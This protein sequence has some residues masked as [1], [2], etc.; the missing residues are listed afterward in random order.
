MMS[1]DDLDRPKAP[2]GGPAASPIS[3]PE[4]R[5]PE[6]R[7]LIVDDQPL[8]VRLLRRIVET[9]G[10]R[11]VRTETDPRAALETFDAFAP[12][13]VI[14]DLHMPGMSGVRMLREIRR[15]QPTDSYLPVL[16]I[17][18]DP[19]PY[20]KR[21]ALAAGARD[22]LAKPF[23]TVE[24][25][26][27]IGSLVETRSLNEDLAHRVAEKTRELE[28]TRDI[29]LLTLA[30]LTESRDPETGRHLE[31]IARYSVTLARAL[32]SDGR[33]PSID[34]T[35]LEQIERSAPLHD[36]GK[37]GI[38]DAIL[39]KP[40]ALT[41]EERR[42]ME[43]HATIGGETLDRVIESFPGHTFLSMAATI[44]HQHH[45]R[46]DGN[47]YP[48]GLAGEEISLGARIVALADAYDAITCERPYE[49]ARSHEEAIERITRDR[50]SHFDP[51]VVDAFLRCERELEQIAGEMVGPG[52]SVTPRVQSIALDPESSHRGTSRTASLEVPGP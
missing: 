3:L 24:V 40:D 25:L 17:T 52:H 11:R 10:Y 21:E 31:R 8:A 15:R 2:Q 12:D 28:E 36:I 34:D 7:I 51:A 38:P 19:A 27:R 46:W 43:E 23:D 26:L 22:F 29:A 5:W 48:R 47:G 4:P 18:A 32:A 1:L 20:I 16:M 42:I 30:K 44:A 6:A 33:H 9:A 49:P 13:L 14:L 50:A 39:L 41:P 35:F 37:V 45:E